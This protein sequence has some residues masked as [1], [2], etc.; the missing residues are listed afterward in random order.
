MSSPPRPHTMSSPEVPVRVSGPEVPTI[1]VRGSPVNPGQVGPTA[2]RAVAP[3][4]PALGS[5]VALV[6]VAVWVSLSAAAGGVTAM[7]AV[8]GPAEALDPRERVAVAVT[9]VVTAAEP[10]EAIVPR[11]HGTVEVPERVPWDGAAD[12]KPTPAGSASDTVTAE[13]AS[14]PAL[15]TSSV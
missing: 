2:V 15:E 3:L 10:P 14:G 12:T 13:A 1:W 7:L 9:A 4:F 6:T 8:A 5:A 11:E